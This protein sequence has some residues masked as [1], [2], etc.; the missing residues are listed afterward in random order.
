MPTKV[1]IVEVMGFPVVMYGCEIWTWKKAEP[2][3]I[4]AFELWCW[5][6]PLRVRWTAGRSN[7]SVLQK[8]TL[9]IHW[10]D[11][12]LSWGSNTLATWWKNQL[13][14]K[15][16]GAW[17]VEGRKSRGREHEMFGWHH[18]LN[19]HEFEQTLGDSEATWGLACCSSWDRRV[20][21]D[22]LTEQ[23]HLGSYTL[24]QERGYVS[25]LSARGPP[26]LST[27]HCFLTHSLEGCTWA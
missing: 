9:G 23:Q 22:I 13:I 18:G 3:R 5:R 7:L 4:I 11:W 14:G 1:H 10:N 8:S 27:V 24:S 26:H 2:Q 21:H 19:G 12:W 6:K 25:R 16:P 20:R 17:K 15:D